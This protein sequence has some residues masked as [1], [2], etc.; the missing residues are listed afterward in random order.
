MNAPNADSHWEGPALEDW[1]PWSPAQVAA[2]LQ[3]STPTWCVVGGWAIDL[4]LGRRTR[5]HSD[6]EIAAPRNDFGSLR[7]ALEP[8]YRLYAA[9]A[10][11]TSALGIDEEFPSSRHQCWVADPA[12]GKW[13]LD[14][15]LEP[16][17]SRR[18][19]F[20][21]DERI[22][23]PRSRMIDRSG[24][25]PFLRPEGVL[26]YKARSPRAKD[27]ADLEACLPGLPPASR[28]WLAASLSMTHPGHRWLELLQPEA[29]PTVNQGNAE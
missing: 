10:G 2:V 7:R 1:A 26:L 11:E 3:H 17:D 9:G 14:L 8:R 19:V 4:W 18:W 27:Q 25:I 20:R 22:Q 16:G 6:I 15:M 5:D 23:Q 28:S 21:R 24:G 13:R 12:S 29:R